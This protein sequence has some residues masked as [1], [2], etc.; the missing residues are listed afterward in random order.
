M[1]ESRLNDNVVS[2]YLSR[3][4]Q[5]SL[6]VEGALVGLFAGGLVTLYRLAL[7]TAEA[8]LRSITS[9]LAQGPFGMAIWFAVLAAILTVLLLIVASAA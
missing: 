9:S 6:V 8:G 7:R 1:P 2:R 3:R 4:F 5:I